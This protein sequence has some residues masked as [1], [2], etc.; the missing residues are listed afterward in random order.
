MAVPREFSKGQEDIKNKLEGNP[1][2]KED[3]DSGEALMMAM[4]CRATSLSG[5]KKHSCN[6]ID[7]I[8]GSSPLGECE[9]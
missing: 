8:E 6:I 9:A 5:Q 2:S 1:Q 4:Q 7:L 3:E